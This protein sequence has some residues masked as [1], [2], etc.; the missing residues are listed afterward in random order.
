MSNILVS[1][2][3]KSLMHDRNVSVKDLSLRSGLT[4]EA[5]NIILISE[6]IPS[7]A[8]L[9]KIARGLGVRPG[10]FL[11]DSDQLGPVIQRHDDINQPV[12][13]SSQLSE[14]NSH[15]D[16]YSLAGN[17]SGRNMEPFLIDIK[18]STSN[19][20]VLS[21]HEGEE[22]LYVLNGSIKVIY[23]IN[24]HILHQGDSIY[25]D[26]IVEHVVCSANNQT[27]KILAV[28]YTPL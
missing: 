11:D 23:G 17:K 16:F 21:S 13:F 1:E 14:K 20:T 25:Y 28:V 5:I 10:T 26:S 22:F 18:P 7:L 6:K 4:E 8:P 24:T 2:K 3:I 9:I 12:S 19:E 27:A 15:L